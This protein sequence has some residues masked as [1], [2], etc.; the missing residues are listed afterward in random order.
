MRGGLRTRLIADSVR[1][2]VIAALDQLG[3]FQSTV[4]DDPPGTRRHRPLRYITRP[5]DWTDDIT[6]NALAISTEDVSDEDLGLGGDV[7]DRLEM[8]LD[9]FAQDEALGL[10][11]IRDIRDIL[12]GK[13]PELGRSAPHVDV[14]DFR[15]ATPAPFTQVEIDDVRVDRAQGEAR[16]WQRYWFMLRLQLLDD[17]ADEFD[18]SHPITK[19]NEDLRPAWELIQQTETNG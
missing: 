9:L 6:P 11:L 16:Q 18:T 4:Y 1:V 15:Q 12:L 14:Y 7:E 17:Y 10:H 19:W 5:V 2:T 3:W 13:F 8:Y